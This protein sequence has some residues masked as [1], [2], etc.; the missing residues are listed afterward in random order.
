MGARSITEL[1]LSHRSTGDEMKP[2]NQISVIAITPD[3][4]DESRIPY[5]ERNPHNPASS[6]FL[7]YIE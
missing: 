7:S 1:I 5:S 2:V 3:W 6:D 4:L